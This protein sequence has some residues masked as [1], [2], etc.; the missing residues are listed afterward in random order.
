MKNSDWMKSI[1]RIKKITGL[2]VIIGFD[3][4]PDPTNHTRSEIWFGLRQRTS[5]LLYA[6]QI[7][8]FFFKTIHY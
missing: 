8:C 3:I 6:L 2:D 1:A 4:K 5:L 7:C